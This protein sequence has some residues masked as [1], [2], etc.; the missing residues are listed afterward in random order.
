MADAPK[1]NIHLQTTGDTSGA[2]KV[3]DSV[4][5]IPGAV[6]PAVDAVNKIPDSARQMDKLTLSTADLNE[7]VRV[8]QWG[9]YDLDAEMAKTGAT[10][11]TL[12][13]GLTK[14]APATGNNARALLM[15][16]QGFEDAQYG[17][18]G[19]LNNIPGLVM[20][21]GGTA[22]LAGAISIAA[23]SFS[24]IYEWLGKTEE[25]ASDVAER[26]QE[27]ST[28]MGEMEAERFDAVSAGID[29]ARDAAAALKETYDATRSAENAFATAALDNA[30]K[31]EKAQLNIA[32]AMGD[33]VSAYQTLAAIAEA[34]DEKRRLA[35]QQAID[36]ENQKLE[37]AREAAAEAGDYLQK[38]R[39]Q[40]DIEAVNLVKL[41][42]QLEVL[43]A[44]A[45]ELKK[46]ADGRGD[47]R[48]LPPSLEEFSQGALA[49]SRNFTDYSAAVRGEAQKQLDASLFQTQLQ[50][51][52]QRVIE[53]QALVQKLSE[54][55]TGAVAKA[56]NALNA[57]QGKVAELEEAVSVNIARIE[58]TLAW[59][60]LLARSETVV[61]S[62]EQTAKD[63]SAAVAQIETTNAQ[64]DAA[65]VTLEAAAADGKITADEAR[66][67]ADSLR[68]IIGQVQAG[69]ATTRGTTQDLLTLL[70]SV[71]EQT[72]SD[73][74]EV[75]QLKAQVAQIFARLR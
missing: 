24:V 50:G 3:V 58:A 29:G 75:R 31:L 72:A 43:R 11:Q 27:I 57:A 6:K 53:L 8:T 32:T 62:G 39:Q 19:V 73:A 45:D 38:K 51:T 68:T 46:I 13:G 67:V 61:K 41:E 44:Q 48:N 25:K 30:A 36:A 16:S 70:R 4:Q 42:A 28:N 10:T 54:E 65:K 74:R 23:V 59:D 15:F 33:Q 37:K 22:G 7:K 71:A 18:R 20:A 5:K 26:I 9:F 55:G 34:E 21:L 52:E 14:L 66:V 40:A 2:D 12:T 47:M 35:A 56:E 17:I 63:I 1:I 69:L 49:K 60:T 64:G